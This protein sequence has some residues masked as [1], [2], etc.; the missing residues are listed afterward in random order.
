MKSG[1]YCSK[2]LMRLLQKCFSAAESLD[3]GM[4]SLHMSVAKRSLRD[5][6]YFLCVSLIYSGAK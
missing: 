6:V 1:G 5:G 3:L 2:F 4:I